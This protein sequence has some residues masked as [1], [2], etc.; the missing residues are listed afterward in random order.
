MHKE[1]EAL[2]S[3]LGRPESRAKPGPLPRP[4]VPHLY[5]N[6]DL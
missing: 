3:G 2:G 4:G 5:F 1:L 6:K